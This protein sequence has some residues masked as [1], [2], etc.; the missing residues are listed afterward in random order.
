MSNPTRTL[1][2]RIPERGLADA[3]E[4]LDVLLGWVADQGLTLY[5][6]Q[7]EAILELYA[8]KHVI[9]ETPTGSGKS[10]V[11]TALHFQEL[12]RARRSVY[13][14]PIKALVSEKF[15][16]LCK[17]FGA[18][19]VGLMT[20]DGSV[21]RDAPL[22][23]CTA[24]VLSNLALRQGDNTGFE[25]VVMDEFHYYGDR[26]RG[27]AWQIPLL[28][29]TKARF[30]LMSATLGDT[31]AIRDDL[32]ERTGREVVRVAHT[33][34]P[35]PLSY[36]YADSPLHDTV[37]K[38]VRNGKSPL[39]VVHF[40]QRAAGE[41]A[42]ALM[43]VDLT[44]K[45]DKKA[46]REAI[47]GFRF[48]SPYGPDLLR[49]LSHGVGLH[50]AG[51]LPKYRLLVEKLAQ[52]GLLRII[53]GTD[54]LGVGINVPI[55]TVLFTQLCKFDGEHVEIL[56]VR[57]FKQIAGRAGRKG[58]DDEGLVVAQA[59][60]WVIENQKREA[61]SK[62]KRVQKKGPPTKG[63]RHWTEDTFRQLIERPPEALKPRF[64]LDHGLVLTLLQRAEAE[65]GDGLAALRELITRS[66]APA[67]D[68]VELERRGEEVLDELVS[69]GIVE[70]EEH[71]GGRV[72]GVSAALQQD[73]SMHN[74]LSLFLIHAIG[75]LDPAEPQYP[76]QVL[77]LVES[78][79]ENPKVVLYAQIQ[80]LK[81]Q[82][83]AALK[84]EG[85]P[86]EERMTALED[87]SWPKPMEHFIYDTFNEYQT[88]HPWVAAENIRPKSIARDMVERFAA[89]S[90]YVKDL[91]IQ[92]AEGVLLRYLTQAYEVLVRS[93]PLYAH[94]PE[95]LDA[96]AFL[97]A[98][99]A[100]VDASL[101]TEWERLLAGEGPV[102]EALPPRP[103]D[104]SLNKKVFIA[105]I[106]AELHALLRSLSRLDWDEAIAGLRRRDPTPPGRPEWTA[107]ELAEAMQPWLEEH[108]AVRFD[109]P[110]RLANNTR[111]EQEGPH[112]WRVSQ[113]LI[114]EEGEIAGSLDG[115]VDLTDDTNPDGP[116]VEL[117]RAG[118]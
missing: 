13:T 90:D 57:D 112:L 19:S 43:S 11:A 88:T 64:K 73:F 80:E 49:F 23:C 10:L 98:T 33:Q 82:L 89:F 62:G 38:L 81:G 110:A 118:D 5:P 106:R 79:L 69:A 85:V 6:A 104:V 37:Q 41:T 54:T 17:L 101:V 114:D 40:T 58:Y 117:L 94:T 108:H 95:L 66:H 105:R 109:G 51:L 36:L 91:G 45:E 44:S 67:K 75:K 83:I 61:N 27:M 31:T 30:L 14:A 107:E 77:T 12:A 102:P 3:D 60:D 47:R 59:P 55:R 46:I 48:D 113:L 56:S 72:H 68:K 52:Q 92:Q 29:M 42:G 39:Y 96:M 93:V 111:V 87:V 2:E 53:C 24:E 86:Y 103:I 71:E 100:R 28:T 65:G 16:A 115:V 116:L 76:L 26:D 22:I 70:R 63:Y 15:F 32:A 34:R 20:G 9:L 7:E 1:G 50:H 21:N 25:S 97:R 8:D 99:L 18:E 84:A 78:V 35:V 74:A 4:A